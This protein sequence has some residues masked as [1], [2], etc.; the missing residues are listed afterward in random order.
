MGDAVN[1]ADI[2]LINACCCEQT[3]FYCTDDCLG[4]SGKSACLCLTCA[5]C[6]KANTDCL[7][8]GP[9][10]LACDDCVILKAQSQVCCL[11]EQCAL[12][13]D[14]EVPF[15]IACCGLACCPK[16]GCCSTLENITGIKQNVMKRQIIFFMGREIK[17]G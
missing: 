1:E 3:G 4:C 6:V 16:C 11:V 14:D 12:P 9:C 8:C 5:Y 15:A 17:Y 2:I 13:C 7:K 10:E